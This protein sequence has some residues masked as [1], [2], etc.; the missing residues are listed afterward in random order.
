[1]T[2]TAASLTSLLDDTFAALR[3]GRRSYQ[4]A[5]ACEQVGRVKTIANGVVWLEGLEAVELEELVQFPG[6]TYGIVLHLDE[7][8]AGVV[9]LGDSTAVRAGDKV[10]RTGRVADVPV[11]DS[12]LGRIVNPLGLP[13]DGK[14]PLYPAAYL[15]IERE[16]PPIMDRLPVE[17]PLQTGLKVLDALIPIG[18]GQRQLIL[19]DRQTGKTAIA[20]DTILNQQASGVLCIYCAIGQ[21][22]ASL[23]KTVAALEA[24]GALAYTVVVIAEG[25]E[26]PGLRYIAPYAATAMGEYFMG[27]GRDVLIV[28]DDLTNHARTYREI[29]LLLRR[30]PGREAFP[31]DIFYIHARLLERCARLRQ[32]KGGG[33]L[34][35]LPII[36]T[37]AQNIS[38]YIPTNLIS[39]TDGQVYLSPALFQKGLLP[40]VDVGRSVS[41]IGG[42]AQLR[43]YHEAA[44]N[45]K[46]AY[47]QFEELEI[48]SRFGTRLDEKTRQTLAH[49]Q[50]IRE[51]LKQPQHRPLGVPQQLLVLLALTE[52]LFDALP[53]ADVAQAEQSLL[54]AASG[55]PQELQQAIGSGRPLRPQ[56]RDRLLQL[57]RKAMAERKE[58]H[59]ADGGGHRPENQ[60]RHGAAGGGAD[61]ENPGGH[62]YRR[63]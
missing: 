41:R 20:V 48:F 62:Q 14:G 25:G 8:E 44:G 35:A 49:G 55:L 56:E 57:L 31:G 43:A 11:G 42:K 29:S 13:L 36:Q 37:E 34:T 17:V 51:C 7:T 22:G 33:S 6:D 3:Q 45:L 15:P 58:N 5:L 40:A 63:V 4:P 61:H 18:R 39:I 46:L 27:Q 24:A 28:Y 54:A 23:A 16:A 60:E 52:G 50:R 10:R 1:M 12:L 59:D 9:L 19:G 26:A 21:H 2:R 53:P 30:P 38:A 47:A 32:D